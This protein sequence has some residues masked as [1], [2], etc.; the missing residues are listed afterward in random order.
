MHERPSYPVRAKVERQARGL[1]QQEVART[2]RVS[3]LA[4]ILLEQG[5]YIPTSEELDRLA[6][7]FQ[8]R[9]REALLRRVSLSPDCAEQNVEGAQ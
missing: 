7:L 1:T 8:I 3:R 6:D 5:R 4:I 2:V 9:P